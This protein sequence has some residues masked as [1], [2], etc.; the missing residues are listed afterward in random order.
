MNLKIHI[1]LEI[2]KG[3]GSTDFGLVVEIS[4]NKRICSYFRTG[5]NNAAKVLK[6]YKEG[7]IIEA[8]IISI[9]DEKKKH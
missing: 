5:M 7:D 9:D 4:R 6:Q 8:K 1:L 3:T 2:Q